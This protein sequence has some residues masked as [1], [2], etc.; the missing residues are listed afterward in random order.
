M[1]Q[2]LHASTS[3]HK[4]VFVGMRPRMTGSA[5]GLLNCWSSGALGFGELPADTDPP[6]TC[7]SRSSCPS[8]GAAAGA[9]AEARPAERG[10]R[11]DSGLRERWAGWEGGR[12]RKSRGQRGLALGGVPVCIGGLG[13]TR[14][15]PP[16]PAQR[17]NTCYATPHN[18]PP[19][20]PAPQPSRARPPPRLRRQLSLGAHSRFPAVP[21][22]PSALPPQ[23]AEVA[24]WRQWRLGL[25]CLIIRTRVCRADSDSAPT[26]VGRDAGGGRGG[27]GG[28]SGRSLGQRGK[29]SKVLGS[30]GGQHLLRPGGPRSWL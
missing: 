30:Q 29:G 15:C 27:G 9:S 4:G 8:L 26:R 14:P 17:G 20:S 1:Y 2:P 25:G 18:F 3:P 5:D 13:R 12:S 24:A 28:C 6:P 21:R 16:S 19:F 10:R 7:P 11:A 22:T 23:L